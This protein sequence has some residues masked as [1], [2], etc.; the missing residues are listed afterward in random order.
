VAKVSA[1]ILIV[2]L[3]VLLAVLGS[4]LG[5]RSIG[6]FRIARPL[7]VAFV[8]IPLFIERPATAGSG[9][10]LELALTGLGALLGTVASTRLMRLSYDSARVAVVSQAGAAYALFWCAFIGA[11]LVFTY[12]ANHWYA[13]ALVHWMSSNGIST[14]ALTDGLIFMAIAM[15][16]TRTI[17][18]AAGRAHAL[19]S[20][21]AELA[22]QS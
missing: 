4:D 7:L 16:V 17:R 19:T 10:A 22:V 13:N 14:D 1:S 9:E 8:I 21:R 11:R 3:A 6:R 18:L 5:T 12:G 20:N 15:T 2:N